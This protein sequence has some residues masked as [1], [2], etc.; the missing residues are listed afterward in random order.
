ME[1]L[2]NMEVGLRKTSIAPQMTSTS[3][4]TTENESEKKMWTEY[5]KE[6]ETYDG[7]ASN[8]WKADS[9]GLLVF[10]RPSLFLSYSPR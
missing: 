5:M 8:S 6:A 9:D 1:A 2:H 4:V 7:R 3:P 10:V